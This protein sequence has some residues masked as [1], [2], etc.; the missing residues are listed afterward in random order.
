MT[1]APLPPNSREAS[2]LLPD[3]IRKCK[4]A[5]KSKRDLLLG[6]GRVIRVTCRGLVGAAAVVV[7]P[8]RDL[9]ESPAFIALAL[10]PDGF[11]PAGKAKAQQDRYG[12]A[13]GK[14]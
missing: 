2:S 10:V 6:S 12:A 7:A 1:K 5:P 9:V 14:P 4:D 8:P 13:A 11:V 3:L